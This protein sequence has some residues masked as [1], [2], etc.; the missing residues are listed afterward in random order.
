MKCIS[1][2]IFQRSVLGYTGYSE[3]KLQA[4]TVRHCDKK[5]NCDCGKNRL[6]GSLTALTVI[7]FLTNPGHFYINDDNW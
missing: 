4:N 1:E 5:K 3:T 7:S 6:A 2:R